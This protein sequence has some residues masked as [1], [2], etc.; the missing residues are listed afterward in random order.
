LIWF[1]LALILGWILTENP[2]SSQRMVIIAP[3]LA[4]LVGVGLDWVVKLLRRLASTGQHTSSLVVTV[5]VLVIVVILNLNYY[6]FEYT[7]SGVYGNPTA[8]VAT[9]LGRYLQRQDDG[10]VVYFYG[11]PTMYWDIGNLRFLA[12]DVVGMSVDEAGLD[13]DVSRGAYFVFL[14]HRQGDLEVIQST[15]PG[16]GTTLVYSDVDVRLLYVMYKVPPP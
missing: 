12:R 7:P 16:G 1:W 13:L 15:F 9:V 5:L 10:Y 14:P 2:P 11:P 4:L 3:A 6:F 8:E